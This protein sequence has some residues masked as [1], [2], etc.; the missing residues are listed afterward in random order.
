MGLMQAF[1]RGWLAIVAGLL[2]P[3]CGFAQYYDSPGLG[4]KPVTTHPQDY[5]PLGIRAGGFMLHPGVQL[6][7]QYT[8]NAFYN[9]QASESDTIFHLRPYLN[10][11][12]TWSKHSLYVRLAADIARYRDY[13]FRDYEDYF[14]QVG[15]K[16][17]VRN[18]SYFT[19]SA[20][21]MN[22][23][24]GLNSRDSEQGLE[25]TRYDLWGASGGYSHTFNRLTLGA[26]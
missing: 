18:R 24:E 9:E 6:A 7:A 13:T 21:Y 4:E 1:A 10:A 20:D 3:A 2:L 12:S 26:Q 22:L 23:H 15:G 5:K 17:D 8:D 25:P 11:Q 16:M 19:Y 14:L